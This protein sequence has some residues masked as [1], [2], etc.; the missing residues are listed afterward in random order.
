MLVVVVDRPLEP[1][2]DIDLD[3]GNTHL[4]GFG[5]LNLAHHR[6]NLAD[7]VFDTVVEGADVGDDLAKTLLALPDVVL[8]IHDRA[9]SRSEFFR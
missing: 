6:D 9:S 8:E 1:D 5:V 3:F 7:A 4:G 2:D